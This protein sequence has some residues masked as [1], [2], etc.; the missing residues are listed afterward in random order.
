MLRPERFEARVNQELTVHFENVGEVAHNL[1]VG[2]FP[3]SERSVQEQDEESSFMVQ[4]ETI[5]PGT[6][7][8]VTFTP[9]S[10][11]TFPYWCDVP[12]HRGA[13]MLGKL[14]VVE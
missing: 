13:G 14:I 11:G 2:R 7:T 1:T 5:Q 9:S 4:S 10:T 8:T 3:T 6:R 12:G